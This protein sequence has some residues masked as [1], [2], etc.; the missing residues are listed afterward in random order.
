MQTDERREHE[1]RTT[2]LPLKIGAYDETGQPF[3][4]E[5]KLRDISG[6]GLSLVCQHQPCCEIGQRLSLNIT[7]PDKGQIALGKATVVWLQQ[8]DT[9]SAVQVGIML[10]DLFS[11]DHLEE[12]CAD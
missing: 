9:D 6:G 7:V 10:D 1:R 12:H 8:T 11:F 4:V 2:E 3:A 5:A